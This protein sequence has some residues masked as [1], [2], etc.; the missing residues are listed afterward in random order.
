MHLTYI[1]IADCSTTCGEDE[2]L[3]V[4]DSEPYGD[5]SS[6]TESGMITFLEYNS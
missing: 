4:A 6:I 2:T 5:S 3:I 1:I